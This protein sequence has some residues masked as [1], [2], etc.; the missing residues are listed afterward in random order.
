METKPWRLFF[1]SLFA[2]VCFAANSLLCRAAL[3]TSVLADAAIDPSSF[4]LLR[5][6]SG[7]LALTALVH[8]RRKTTSTAEGSWP[9]ALALAIYMVFFSFAYIHIDAGVGALV[10]FGVVQLTMIGSS[11]LKGSRPKKYE[12]VGLAVAFVGLIILTVPGKTKPTLISA[13]M[14]AIAGIGWGAY[15]LLGRKASNPLIVT[16]GNF[17]RSFV[18]VSIVALLFKKSVHLTPAG[19]GLA[20]VSGVI[21]SGL[22]YSIWY[23]AL[24]HLGAIISTGVL[25]KVFLGKA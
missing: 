14:M 13:L 1:F 3:R 6:S 2:L 21:T 22:G 17:T 18:L 9:G 12:W 24:P 23:K 16:A 10:L 4:A 11:F 5:I 25:E 7:A 20:M 15:S 8:L 19:M